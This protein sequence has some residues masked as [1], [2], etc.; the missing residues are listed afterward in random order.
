[1]GDGPLRSFPSSV[2]VHN[3]FSRN[4][5]TL[6]A[7]AAPRRGTPWRWS[8][9]GEAVGSVKGSAASPVIQARDRKTLAIVVLAMAD[10]AAISA[11]VHCEGTPTWRE[12]SERGGSNGVRRFPSTPPPP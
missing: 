12:E 2:V 11:S 6:G 10:K 1:M 5:S 8:K 7:S 9:A 3:S 4:T